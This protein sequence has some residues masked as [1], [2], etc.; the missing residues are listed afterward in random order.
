VPT[1][2]NAPTVPTPLLAVE[3]SDLRRRGAPLAVIAMLDPSADVDQQD[4][5][6]RYGPGADWLPEG[7]QPGNLR[8]V[9]LTGAAGEI[10]VLPGAVE[11]D[12]PGEHV[13]WIVGAGA[14]TAAEWRDAGA[15]LARS[16]VDLEGVPSFDVHL[17]TDVDAVEVDA[18]VTGLLLGGYRFRVSGEPRPGAA[19]SVRLCVDGDADRL[20]AAV[21]RAVVLGSATAVGRDMANMPS[22]IK[23]P[24][25]LVGKAVELCAGLPGLTVTVR[26]EQ[27]LTEQGFGG[28]LAVGGGSTRRPAFAELAWRPDGSAGA[29]H[30]VVVGKGV[31]FDSGGISIKPAENMHLMRTDMSGAA[32]VIASVRAIA[33][34][35]LPVRVTGLVPAAENHVSGSSYRPGDIVRHF[36]GKTT[37]VVNTDAE[38]RMLLADGLAYAV[39]RLAPDYLV[40][41]ATLTGAMKI[42]L[43][44]RIGGLFA[45]DAALAARIEAAGESVGERWWPMPFVE[46]FA[47]E[48]VSH[49]ADLR[50]CPP[51]PGAIT[52]AMFLREFTGGLPW[53][54]LDIAGPARADRTYAEVVPGGTG[55]AARTLIALAESLA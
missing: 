43:G 40:D 53:A 52:A 18:F 24:A 9:E 14:R 28:L 44:L 47:D 16:V 54:H 1:L 17:P 13:R 48:L 51:G 10:R 15:A 29:P 19:H 25:W 6:P 26:D 3:L 4:A 8:G 45:T 55:F 5:R 27:W 2:T 50:Q 34:L 31:T 33:Q 30:L 35:G 42:A 20:A 46:D 22:N 37:E 41:V 23:D 11:L 12:G 21:H 38:G 49:I 39:A 36:G 7:W 32:A